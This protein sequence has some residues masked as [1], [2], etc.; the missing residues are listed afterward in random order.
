MSEIAA[1]G[2]AAARF[3]H[4]IVR[5]SKFKL[6]NNT[7]ALAFCRSPRAEIEFRVTLI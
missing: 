2:K 7:A 3:T 6:S 1:F 5:R 4:T